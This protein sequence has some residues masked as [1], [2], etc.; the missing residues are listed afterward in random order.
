MAVTAAQII[1]LALLDAGVSARGQVASG[2]DTANALMRLKMIIS[3]W[4]RRRWLVFHLVDV[5]ATLTGAQSYSFGPGQTFDAP[6]TDQIEAAFI[7]QIYPSSGSP[8]DYPVGVIRSYEDYSQITLKGLQGGPSWLVFYDSGWPNGTVYP[9]PIPNVGITYELHLIVKAA[10]QDITD[11]Q[12]DLAFPDE[13]Q[14]ALYSNLVLALCAAYKLPV[15][16]GMVAIAKASLETLR[17]SNVQVPTMNMPG[18]V[19][20]MSGG[21][22]NIW[23]DSWGPAGR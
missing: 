4:A 3:Q 22:Y 23:S 10:L 17:T 1:S 8:I 11:I 5:H 14:Q 13:Y 20:P 9:W 21:G 2:E 19:L 7:R 15:D 6:R 18:A 12:A 16:P